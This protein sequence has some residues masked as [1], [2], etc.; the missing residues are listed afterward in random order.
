MP[1]ELTID[2][3]AGDKWVHVLPPGWQQYTDAPIEEVCA[4]QWNVLNQALSDA[5]S[6][7]PT[8]D[9][10]RI[11]YESLLQRPVE[12]I[13]SLFDRLQLSW[14]NDVESHV[15]SLDQHV[16]NTKTNPQLGKWR[17]RNPERV[18]RILPTIRPVMEKL[19]YNV[20]NPA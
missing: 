20:P 8:D 7:L 9:L 4:H 10:V 14:T 1:K 3:Y 12:T 19:G 13:H 15:R 11:R 5:E 16:V 2:G 17:D 6:R 18:A